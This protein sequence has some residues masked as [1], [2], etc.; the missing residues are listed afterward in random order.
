MAKRLTIKTFHAFGAALLRR[1][2]EKPRLA[3]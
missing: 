3:V 2:G 1:Y